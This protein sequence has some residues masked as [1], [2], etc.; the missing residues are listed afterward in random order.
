MTE[1]EGWFGV[2][3]GYVL[4]NLH[5]KCVRKSSSESEQAIAILK[6][7]KLEDGCDS[8]KRTSSFSCGSLS[9][10]TDCADSIFL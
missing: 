2:L 5:K 9:P 4:Q 6:A 1:R 8:Q 3:G 7:S 10:I